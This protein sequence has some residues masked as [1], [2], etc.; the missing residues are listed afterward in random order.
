MSGVD[1]TLLQWRFVVVKYE[2]GVETGPSYTSVYLPT[3][4]CNM[5][6]YFL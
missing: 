2:V 5:C 1:S 4:M 6:D 3:V